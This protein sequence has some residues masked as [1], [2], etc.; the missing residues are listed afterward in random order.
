MTQLPKETPLP[1][2]SS[3]HFLFFA[4]PHYPE[5]FTFVFCRLQPCLKISPY[6]YARTLL[7]N[8]SNE[9]SQLLGDRTPC[10]RFSPVTAGIL[11]IIVETD[12]KKSFIRKRKSV[13][14]MGGRYFAPACNP[15]INPGPTPWRTLYHPNGFISSEFEKL[16]IEPCALNDREAD[17]DT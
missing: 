17:I 3:T 15:T 4:S 6:I 13:G 2:P 7:K 10:Q 1:T 12:I 5:V 9:I 11:F 16:P 14:Y 8:V